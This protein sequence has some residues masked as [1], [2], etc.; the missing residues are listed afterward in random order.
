MCQES[1]TEGK[2][3]RKWRACAKGVVIVTHHRIKLE[4]EVNEEMEGLM[5][6]EKGEF[7]GLEVPKE[8]KNSK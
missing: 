2:G 6:S 1:P 8:T 5:D 4:R 3:P 7:S